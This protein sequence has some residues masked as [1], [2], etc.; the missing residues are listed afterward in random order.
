MTLRSACLALPLALLLA[1]AHADDRP[2]PAWQQRRAEFASI[3]EGVHQ[4]DAAA[5]KRLDEVLSGL[6]ARQMQRTPMENMEIM[7]VYYLPREGLEKALPRI[8]AHATLGWYDTLR[9]SS[10]PGRSE[11]FYVLFQLPFLIAAPDA[12]SK[13]VDFF[14]AHPRETEELVQQG[15]AMARQFRTQ[16]AY[17]RHWPGAFG[18]NELVCAQGGPCEVAQSLPESQWEEAWQQAERLV[19]KSYRSDDSQVPD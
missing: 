8:A 7:G 12:S 4:G 9:F 10:A 16:V 13:A 15:I 5:R 3:L 6:E 19:R 14:N 18:A 11:I 2:K 1:T 17:D